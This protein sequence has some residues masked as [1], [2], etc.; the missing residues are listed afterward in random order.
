MMNHN[1]NTSKT[2]SHSSIHTEPKE[3]VFEHK[4]TAHNEN[5]HSHIQEEGSHTEKHSSCGC[6]C[7]S[8][9]KY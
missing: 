1:K 9:L 5:E 8:K 3:D 6:G 2:K 4:S 7:G